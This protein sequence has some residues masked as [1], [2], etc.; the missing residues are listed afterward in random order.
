M[1]EKRSGLFL[2][3][4]HTL[5]LVLCLDGGVEEGVGAGGRVE[6]SLHYKCQEQLEG[7]RK[8]GRNH[9]SI[10]AVRHISYTL[11]GL[12]LHSDIDR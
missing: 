1:I 5:A 3:F 8:A 10:L 12:S 11:Q 2:F 6:G 4:F 9:L 7:V